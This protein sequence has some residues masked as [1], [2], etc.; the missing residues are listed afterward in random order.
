ME[1]PENNEKQLDK[2]CKDKFKIM[3]LKVKAGLDYAP[4]LVSLISYLASNVNF[5]ADY[6]ANMIEHLVVSRPHIIWNIG[7]EYS[8]I[9]VF[10]KREPGCFPSLPCVKLFF[11]VA[12]VDDN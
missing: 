2:K 12:L 11:L 9:H 3:S 6:L 5:L 10:L 1:Q 8:E 4:E 7:N